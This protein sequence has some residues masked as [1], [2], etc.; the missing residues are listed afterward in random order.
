MNPSSAPIREIRRGSL[1][2]GKQEMR[3]GEQ[4]LE[5][6]TDET[7]SSGLSPCTRYSGTR[8][9]RG[10]HLLL[11]RGIVMVQVHTVLLIS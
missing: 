2:T 8:H 1:V 5:R 9:G 7:P 4:D 11:S 3:V 10:T 6:S